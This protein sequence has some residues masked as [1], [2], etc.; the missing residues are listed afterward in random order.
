MRGFVVGIQLLILKFAKLKIAHGVLSV[1]V[2]KETKYRSKQGL[3]SG[4]VGLIGSQLPLCFECV[5]VALLSTY[6]SIDAQ[7]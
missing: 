3:P 6:L 2:N 5:T 1:L 4:M 7:G